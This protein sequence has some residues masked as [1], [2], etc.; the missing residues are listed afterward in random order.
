MH[1]PL[2]RFDNSL[3][4]SSKFVSRPAGYLLMLVALAFCTLVP[5]LRSV[6]AQP[7][8]WAVKAS[9]PTGRTGAAAAAIGGKLYVVGGF[10]NGNLSSLEVYDPSTD[11]W[12]TKAPM[13][14]ARN[15]LAAA[16]I[17]G[18]LYV[19]GGAAGCCPLSNLEV[20]DPSTDTWTTKASMPTARTVLAAAAIDTKLYVIGGFNVDVGGQTPILEVYDSVTDVWTAK[21]PMPTT[22]IGLAAAPINGKLYAV[23]GSFNNNPLSTVEVYDPASDTWAAKTSMPTTINRLAAAALDGKIYAAGGS[24]PLEVYDAATDTWT[25]KAAMPTS[26]TSLAAAAF[27]GRFYAVGGSGSNGAPV[28]A[29]EAYKVNSNEQVEPAL[30]SHWR[31]ES[32]TNDSVG[33]NDGTLHNGATYSP[34]FTGAALKFDGVSANFQSPTLGLPTGNADRTMSAWVRI[35]AY[36]AGDAVIAAYG[37]WNALDQLYFL[38]IFSSGNVY[39]SQWGQSIV[40]PVLNL[41]RWYHIAVTNVGGQTK[42]YVD[43]Q[44]VNS[45]FQSINTSDNS[46]FFIGST[47]EPTG[48]YGNFALNGEVDEVKVYNRALTAEEIL[49]QV[50]DWTNANPIGLSPSP[51]SGHRMVYDSARSKVIMIGGENGFGFLNEVW[52]WDTASRTW[53]NVTPTGG[54]QPIPRAD[55]GMAYDPVRAKVV[56]YGGR[57]ST[58]FSNVGIT[59]DTWEWEPAGGT[60]TQKPASTLVFVGLWG[61]ELAFDPNLQKVIVFGGEPY[62]GYP[63]NSATYAWDDN[64]WTLIS[65]DGPSGRVR[66][67]MA[68]DSKRS[69]VIL[70]GGYNRSSSGFTRPNDT[71]EW[72]GQAWIQVSAE[73]PQSPS[74]GDGAVMAYDTRRELTFLFGGTYSQETWSW[75]GQAWVKW[76]PP[77]SPSARRTSMAYDAARS[78]LVMFGGATPSGALGDTYL[79]GLDPGTVNTT[80]TIS[81]DLNPSAFGSGVTFTA[82][83]AGGVVTE[84][85]VTFKEGSTI[86]AGP[87]TLNG[88]GQVSF[89]TSDLTTGT[90]TITAE[91][92]GANNLN[93][94]SDSIVQTVDKADQTITFGALGSKTFG[95]APFS[96]SAMASSGLPVSFSIVSGPA[97]AS[98]STVT[99]NGAGN[100]VVR[101]SQA[102]SFDYNAAPDVDQSFTVNKATPTINWSNPADIV[103]GTALSGA[104]LNATA[105]V[106]G[107]FNYTPSA[108]TVL[109]AGNGQTLS[110]S[111]TPTDTTNYNVATATVLININKRASSTSLSSSPNPSIAGQPVTFIASVT[112]DGGPTPTGSVKVL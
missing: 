54:N 65:I 90:H 49:A 66:H 11:A 104:Q 9:M 64:G 47:T 89:S 72:N 24:S 44:L 1:I 10:N 88:N 78:H 41:N 55:F 35:N 33:S 52:E 81:S 25:A 2:V 62:W 91:Y 17:A 92:G 50:P 94:S 96:L 38:G 7:D 102:G 107:T 67:S 13:P 43:G 77:H 109:N 5:V 37:T 71:W 99:I 18:K 80:T 61:A 79:Y 53:T 63:T 21:A 3:S 12:T 111:F 112:G 14:T 16:A 85:T 48:G 76:L 59:G 60:W 40:G 74:P 84:G 101:A 58:Q 26:R 39:F 36:R 30:I 103:Y 68:T 93:P 57:C 22:R 82:T 6:L 20:Y 8:T 15:G 34:G 42:L 83:V 106:P 95:A 110:V 73:G 97:T 45:G 32:N 51:R 29:L 87:M 70:F 19:V 23:G 105:S 56:I 75:D 108:G 27:D 31:A 4:R 86:L 69:R 28:S 46:N 98:G 100:V